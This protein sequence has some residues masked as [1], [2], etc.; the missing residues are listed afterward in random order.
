VSQADVERHREAFDAFNRRDYDAFLALADRD[1]ELTPLT[2]GVEGIRSYRGHNGVRAWWDDLLAVFPDFHA[3]AEEIRDL[4]D[5][6][7]AR[8]RL[9]GRG[10]ES[11]ASFERQIWQ[12]VEWRRGRVVRWRTF[13]S[14][15][16]AIEAAG[17]RD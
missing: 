13:M 11:D 5:L 4:G 3:E 6:T 7:V 8:G 14:E 15:A 2:V 1:V 16:E 12:V 9:R 10:V 17:S